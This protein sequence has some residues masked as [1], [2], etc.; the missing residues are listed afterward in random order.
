MI[1]VLFVTGR[2]I[3]K[4]IVQLYQPNIKMHVF[5]VGK[6]IIMQKIA[7]PN[8]KVNHGKNE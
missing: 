5:G 6:K 4:I 2:D 1:F 7:I 3:G 8:K